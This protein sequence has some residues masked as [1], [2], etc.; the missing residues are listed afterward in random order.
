MAVEYGLQYSPRRESR[1][2]CKGDQDQF[3]Q[4]LTGLYKIFAVGPCPF[5]DILDGSPLGDKLLCLDLPTNMS[6]AD[7]HRRISV[8]S[9]KPSTYPHD[10]GDMPKYLM[11]GLTLYVLNNFTIKSLNIA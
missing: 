2:G 7:A 10:R 6:G 9:C 4:N 3:A 1:N 5:S 8:E 11:D